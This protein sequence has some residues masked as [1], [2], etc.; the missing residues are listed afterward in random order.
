M[1]IETMS[2]IQQQ[3]AAEL[4]AEEIPE[5]TPEIKA[6]AEYKREAFDMPTNAVKVDPLR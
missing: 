1:N 3:K 5:L 6:L 4:T 2:E